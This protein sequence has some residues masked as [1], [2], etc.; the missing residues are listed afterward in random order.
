MESEDRGAATLQ[1]ALGLSIYKLHCAL[2]EQHLLAEVL[3]L[4]RATHH[5]I[6]YSYCSSNCR[7][8]IVDLLF[9]Y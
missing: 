3:P 9:I 1:N 5:L 4:I 7:A 8:I 2:G 6:Y